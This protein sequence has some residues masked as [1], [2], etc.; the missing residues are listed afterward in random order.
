MKV[1]DLTVAQRPVSLHSASNSTQRL[2]ELPACLSRIFLSCVHEKTADNRF[3]HTVPVF[4][5]ADKIELV[6][7]EE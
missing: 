6:S 3:S 5:A 1:N 2:R 7:I 4:A